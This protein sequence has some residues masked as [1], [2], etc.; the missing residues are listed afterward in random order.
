[1]EHAAAVLLQ[2]V[3]NSDERMLGLLKAQTASSP[4]AVAE[5]LRPWY[6]AMLLMIKSAENFDQG[7]SVP[8]PSV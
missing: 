2:T 5:F 8:Q 6:Q 7:P 1:V 4:Q 3:F